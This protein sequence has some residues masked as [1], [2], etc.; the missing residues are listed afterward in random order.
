MAELTMFNIVKLSV[1]L[2]S[3]LLLSF[4]YSRQACKVMLKLV[5]ASIEEMIS[6]L[7]DFP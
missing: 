2:R 7:F 3:F 1:Y 6:F 5:N 4:D